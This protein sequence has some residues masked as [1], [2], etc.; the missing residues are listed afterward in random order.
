VSAPRRLVPGSCVAARLRARVRFRGGD[1]LT[2]S[3]V[4]CALRQRAYERQRAE[5]RLLV[6]AERRHA[7]VTS[8]M[9]IRGCRTSSDSAP[10]GC[11]EKP[12]HDMASWR[13]EAFPWRVSL[14][15]GVAPL[16]EPQLDSQ[17][18]CRSTAVGKRDG[19]KLQLGAQ[20]RVVS[21]TL[22][23]HSRCHPRRARAQR[24]E[25]RGKTSPRHS[26]GCRGRGEDKPQRAPVAIAVLEKWPHLCPG[27]P[28][29]MPKSKSPEQ[30]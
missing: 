2:L 30:R 9:V 21:A 17:S 29:P 3:P 10:R 27:R 6:E 20:K 4:E 18:H 5:W 15:L 22:R 12:R 14:C 24:R 7:S 26:M 16:Q 1:G 28:C 8:G 19:I 25:S 11:G 13:G 23:N